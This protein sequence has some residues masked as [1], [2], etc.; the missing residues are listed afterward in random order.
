MMIN[1]QSSCCVHYF[2]QKCVIGDG[3]EVMTAKRTRLTLESV[4]APMAITI[5]RNLTLSLMV[6]QLPTL[7]MRFTP[8]S[9]INSEQ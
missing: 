1:L 7:N 2:F 5:S 3:G 9:R 4:D 6:P 8:Y